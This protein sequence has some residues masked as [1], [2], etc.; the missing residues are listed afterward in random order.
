[1][2]HTVKVVVAN[3]SRQIDY[4]DSERGWVNIAVESPNGLAVGVYPLAEASPV[5]RDT[6]MNY[7][8]SIVHVDRDFVYQSVFNGRQLAKHD[9]AAFPRDAVPHVG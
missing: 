1:M 5:A 9:V 3:S 6:S 2:N 4:Y 8:G 7:S